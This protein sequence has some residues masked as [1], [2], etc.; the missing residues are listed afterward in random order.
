VTSHMTC[1]LCGGLG[2]LKRDCHLARNPEMR[3]Q[4]MNMPPPPRTAMVRYSCSYMD[5]MRWKLVLL[6]RFRKLSAFTAHVV[7]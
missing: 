2:H 1:H 5:G 3:Y 7:K 6:I 4:M